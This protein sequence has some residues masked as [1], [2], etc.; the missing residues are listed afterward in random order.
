MRAID[1]YAGIGGWSV[2]LTMAGMN[3]V[4]SYERSASANATNR[5]N[6]GHAVVQADIRSL[7]VEDLPGEVSVLVGSPPCTQFSYSNRGGGGDLA[8]GLEDIKCFLRA[9]RQLQPSYWAMEN[10]PRLA[11]V[12]EAELGPEGALAEFQDL[13]IQWRVFDMQNFGVP[14]KRLRCIVGNID[15]DLL[16]SYEAYLPRRTLGSVVKALAGDHAFDPNYGRC[17]PALELADHCEEDFL[18]AEEVRINHALKVLHPVYN[19]MKF[20]DSLERPART[21][22]A[23]C[24]R[25]SRES[26]VIPSDQAQGS[27]RRLTI[28]ERATCQS[29]PIT[30]QLYAG[31]YN[32][33]LKMVGNAL[34]P[35][36][37]YYVAK[38]MQG[39]PV[40]EICTPSLEGGAFLAERAVDSRPDRRMVRYKSDRTFRFA[41]P[42]LRLG[43]GIRFELTNNAQTGQITW[44][45]DFVFGTSKSIHSI[46]P[47]GNDMERLRILL[48]V[49]AAR[50]IHSTTLDLTNALRGLDIPHLQAVWSHRGPGATR[51]FMLLDLLDTYGVKLRTILSCHASECKRA[52]LIFADAYSN[53]ERKH[54]S[55][56][57]LIENSVTVIAGL[58]V[59]AVMNEVT[60][61]FGRPPTVS[62]AVASKLALG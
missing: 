35:L 12:L 32:E 13:A 15:F 23:T 49:E 37:A 19:S 8:D 31:S 26:I 4:A 61:A 53:L 28:R 2:G 51:P 52:L 1:L 50:A 36:F 43:S 48:G 56:H 22:T 5:K 25:V 17:I 27:Y 59:S 39:T 42:Q 60:S 41:V 44:S 34:P 58:V 3:V 47:A 14:Q 20:P 40:E 54:L 45:I 10:V 33:K 38:S 24:T 21:I 6:N 46:R 55:S 11:K 9:V 16:S 62:P 57:K 30:F 18:D 29:F 7:K